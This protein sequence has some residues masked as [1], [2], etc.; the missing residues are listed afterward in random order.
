LPFVRNRFH[1]LPKRDCNVRALSTAQQNSFAVHGEYQSMARSRSYARAE[2]VTFGERF[3]WI[4]GGGAVLA[5][6]SFQI[7]FVARLAG[8]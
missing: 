4:V 7:I 5:L 6:I 2:R 1:F 8:F 3:G